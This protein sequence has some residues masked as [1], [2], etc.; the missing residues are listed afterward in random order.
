MQPLTKSQVSDTSCQLVVG[1]VALKARVSEFLSLA[2]G[3]CGGGLP[4][5]PSGKSAAV[6]QLFLPVCVELQGQL[7]VRVQ[8]L[9][10]YFLDMQSLEHVHGLYI[11]G[12]VLEFIKAPMNLSFPRV[13]S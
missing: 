7:E 12:N 3:L 4:L 11:P 1:E 8:D 2:K 10:G 5:M 6:P 13:S 9:F